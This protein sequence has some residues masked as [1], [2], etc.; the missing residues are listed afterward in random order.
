MFVQPI[1][2]GELGG[3]DSFWQAARLGM[4]L[5]SLQTEF[6]Q[7]GKK[8]PDTYLSLFVLLLDSFIP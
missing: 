5:P 3:K 2:E 6:L 1:R 4:A 7:G 8:G